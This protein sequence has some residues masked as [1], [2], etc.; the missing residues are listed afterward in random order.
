M[1]AD[2]AENMLRTTLV[3][4]ALVWPSLSVAETFASGSAAREFTD[5]VPQG[6]VINTFNF[7]DKIHQMF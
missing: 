1:T 5:K 3:V 2:K 7:D 4:F 6:W